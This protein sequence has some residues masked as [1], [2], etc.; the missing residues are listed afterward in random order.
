MCVCCYWDP[1]I[2]FLKAFFLGRVVKVL[3]RFAIVGFPPLSGPLL[4]MQCFVL[5]DI[6]KKGE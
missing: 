6:L 4:K 5:V 1:K 2:A 3:K